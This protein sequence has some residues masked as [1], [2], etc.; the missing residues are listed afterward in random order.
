MQFKVS[1]GELMRLKVRDLSL[2]INRN[3]TAA[4]RRVTTI[5]RLSE[6]LMPTEVEP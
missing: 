5:T 1:G 2:L 6:Y 3:L 4:R